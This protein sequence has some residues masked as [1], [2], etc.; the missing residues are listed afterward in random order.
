MSEL[1]VINN[2]SPTMAGLKTG[3][4]FCCDAKSREEL[5]GS[6]KGFNSRLV[7]KGIKFLPLRYRNGRALVYVYRPEKLTNDLNDAGAS[8]ILKSKNYPVG[9][10]EKCVVELIK[11]LR[12]E[13]DFPHEIGLFLGY[14]PVDVYGFMHCK[15]KNF[16]CVGTWKVYGDEK[17]A[18]RQFESFKKCTDAYKRAYERHKSFDKLVVSAK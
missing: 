15:A 3:N 4:L 12:T 10:C 17:K 8:K 1:Q 7:K 6:I 16:K 5:N 13:Q 14:P 11:R 9:N 18:K 2:C